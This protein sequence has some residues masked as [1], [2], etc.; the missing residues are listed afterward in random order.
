MRTSIS[1]ANPWIIVAPGAALALAYLVFVYLPEHRAINALR[2]QL[3]NTDQYVEGGQNLDLAAQATQHEFDKARAYVRVWEECAPS[4][5]DLSGL[6]GRINLL[7]RDSGATTVRFD[8]QPAVP[9]DKLR[10]IPVKM[11]CVGSFAQVSKFLQYV[12][13]LD[14]TIWIESLRME[15]SGESGEDVQCELTLGIFAGNWD[16]SD[17]VDHSG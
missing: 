16:D 8:P 4:E 5:D 10:R 2:E 13:G 1:R 14:E 15:G 3:T 12:E 11:A 7:A 17:Q 6:F 9:Y